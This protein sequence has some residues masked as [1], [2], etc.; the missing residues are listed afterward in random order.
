MITIDD[1]VGIPE[2]KR[3]AVICCLDELI[4]FENVRGEFSPI[5]SGYGYFKELA[6]PTSVLTF[7]HTHKT[8]EYKEDMVNDLT[9]LGYDQDSLLKNI[10]DKTA[11]FL[12]NPRYRVRDSKGEILPGLKIKD[13]RT[14]EHIDLVKYTRRFLSEYQEFQERKDLVGESQEWQLDMPFENIEELLRLVKLFLEKSGIYVYDESGVEVSATQS[15][16]RDA[17]ETPVVVIG[18]EAIK[19][20]YLLPHF[21]TAIRVFLIENGNEISFI[22]NKN[23]RTLRVLPHYERLRRFGF[24]EERCLVNKPFLKDIDMR[25]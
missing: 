12:W 6:L 23:I 24:R 5:I 4:T 7:S 19:H 25:R 3:K 15:H 10:R 9:K 21:D 1:L 17:Y 14:G 13:L 16:W 20:A 18:E 2:E 8:K 11:V 22:I